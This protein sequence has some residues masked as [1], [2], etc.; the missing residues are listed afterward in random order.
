MLIKNL[1]EQTTEEMKEVLFNG[2]LLILI[3]ENKRLEQK[4]IMSKS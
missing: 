2:A 3:E 4:E 1:I